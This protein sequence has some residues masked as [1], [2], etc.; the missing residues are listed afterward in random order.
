MS[1]DGAAGRLADELGRGG[2]AAWTEYENLAGGA[3]A[4]V[5]RELKARVDRLVRSDPAAALPVS[6]ALER[7]ARSA[8]KERVLALRGRAVALYSNG[9]K[10]GALVAYEQAERSAEAAGDELEVARV[11]RSMVD[12]LQMSG[13]APEA[14]ACAD[15]ARETFARLGELRLLA[16]LE[17]NVGNVHFRLDDHPAARERYEVARSLFERLEDPVGIAFC[18]FNLGNLEM[19]VYAFDRAGA[20]FGEARELMV[21]EGMEVVVADCDYSLACLEFRKGHFARAVEGLEAAR[22]VYAIDGKPSG[23]PLCDLEL[24]EIYLQ[25]DLRRDA[26]EHSVRAIAAFEGLELDYESARARLVA[27]VARFRLGDPDAARTDLDVARDLACGL[28]NE[29]LVAFVD[30]L[31]FGI[32]TTDGGGADELERVRAAGERLTSSGQ[33]FLADVATLTLARGLI[34][35]G[36]PRESVSLLDELAAEVRASSPLERT[37]GAETFGLLGD[38]WLALDRPAEAAAALESAVASAEAAYLEV[39]G[40]HGRIAFFRR[41]QEAFLE[42]ARLRAHEGDARAALSLLERGRLRSASFTDPW[43]LEADGELREARAQLDSLL[44]ARLDAELG[45]AEAPGPAAALDDS[46]LLAAERRL[47][48]L[49]REQLV[50]RG[51]APASPALETPERVVRGGE[52]LL[53]FQLHRRGSSVLVVRPDGV[54]A[55]PL[56]GGPGDL[57]RLVQQLAYQARKF[58]LGPE[59]VARHSEQLRSATD[60]V[61]DQLGELLLAPVEDLLEGHAIVV[62]P[63]G[64]LH[65]VPFHALRLRGSVVVERYEVSYAPSL[66][67]LGRRRSS[68]T[69]AGEVLLAGVP[70][71]SAPLIGQELRGV[72]ASFPDRSRRVPEGELLSSLAPSGARA[73][74]LHI[75]AHG[76]FRP[77]HPVFSGVRVGGGFLTVHDIRQVRVSL[78]LV[79]LSG[80]E[81]GRRA[82]AAGGELVGPDHAF[83]V[84]GARSVV[85]SLWV[86]GD[87][88]S[89]RM[90]GLFYERL[91]EGRTVREALA[92][93][94]R[95]VAASDPHLWSW[96]SFVLQGD[97]LTRLV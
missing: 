51:A 77:G 97:P 29:S 54:F 9:D 91:A 60:R 8:P 46:A 41:P 39:P 48:K 38:A 69:V 3:R 44:G 80:C 7:A 85:S 15:R 24:A 30:L 66:T 20:A 75:A 18:A 96:A 86:V 83:L 73:S 11:R 61:L 78:D 49:S 13:R 50:D 19:G 72:E 59:Y 79:T 23:V 90:M 82:E 35:A 6:E 81:T 25:L 34:A 53:A 28:G 56:A 88:D 16:Q 26:L 12:V 4:A 58:Q 57:E 21:R 68:E 33:R 89:A 65:R 76:T 63:D 1:G 95:E 27:G 32:V 74:A 71:E 10:Q 62:V 67:L 37:L 84:A 42:L 47:A 64:L 55:R 5:V 94:Q 87:A 14:F 93:T 70:E 52:V 36:Q 40:L 43:R 31:Q 92:R 2:A 17:V 22:S 45:T